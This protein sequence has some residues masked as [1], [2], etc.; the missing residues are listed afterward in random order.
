M[1]KLLCSC[2]KA[3]LVCTELCQCVLDDGDCDNVDRIAVLDEEEEK[4]IRVI[5]TF[6]MRLICIQ[7][8]IK[9]HHVRMSSYNK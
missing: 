1:P 5:M 4:D 2:K 8:K 9:R 7:D 6:S 3:G